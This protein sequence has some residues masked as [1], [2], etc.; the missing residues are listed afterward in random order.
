MIVT[1]AHVLLVGFT[2]QEKA[3]E[4]AQRVALVLDTVQR[5]GGWIKT[6]T[7]HAQIGA[8]ARQL[9]YALKKFEASGQVKRQGVK[10]KTE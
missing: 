7:I 10:Q 5:A 3:R 9:R 6:P 8:A 4:V 1:R 2:G